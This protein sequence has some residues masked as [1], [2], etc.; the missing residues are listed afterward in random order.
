M[1]QSHNRRPEFIEAPDNR[2]K[3]HSDHCVGVLLLVAGVAQ[4]SAAQS[5]ERNFGALNLTDTAHPAS[6]TD[7]PSHLAARRSMYTSLM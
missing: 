6:G 1:R 7:H 5:H 3:Y 4:T 2:A